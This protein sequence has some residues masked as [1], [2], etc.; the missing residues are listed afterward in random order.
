MK[1]TGLEGLIKE[2]GIELDND[3]LLDVVYPS[4][5]Q[6]AF[7]RLKGVRLP[8]RPVM[9]V[10]ANKFPEHEITADLTKSRLFYPSLEH[11]LR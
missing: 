2:F 9:T 10:I 6:R 5:V 3:C 1:K 8:P 7:A 11:C 4:L